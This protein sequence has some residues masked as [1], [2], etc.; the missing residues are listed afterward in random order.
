MILNQSDRGWRERGRREGGREKNTRK[1]ACAQTKTIRGQTECT[2]GGGLGRGLGLGLTG[3]RLGLALVGLRGGLRDA[4]RTVR[5]NSGATPAFGMMADGEVG[6]LLTRGDTSGQVTDFWPGAKYEARKT[7]PP[8]QIDQTCHLG[9]FGAKN[10]T[11]RISCPF[12]G[13]R[14]PPSRLGQSRTMGKK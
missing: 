11:E 4:V 10:W 13:S 8:P 3:L 6:F 2:R 9:L 5:P 7:V 1:F 12:W 14:V